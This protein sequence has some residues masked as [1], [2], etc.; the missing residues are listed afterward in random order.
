MNEKLEN[1][2]VQG[3]GIVKSAVRDGFDQARDDLF[4]EGAETQQHADIQTAA[5]ML[6]EAGSSELTV[7]RLLIRYWDLN[8]EDAEWYASVGGTVQRLKRFAFEMGISGTA[9]REYIRLGNAELEAEKP[10]FRKKPVEKQYEQVLSTARDNGW[11]P[12]II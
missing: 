2:I 11:K 9:L 4:T 1:F 6:L 12:Q 10:A 8:R 5:A 3:M 7:I